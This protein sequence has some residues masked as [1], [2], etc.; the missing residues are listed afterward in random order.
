MTD[1]D[2]RFNFY[3]VDGATNGACCGLVIVACFLNES[4]ALLAVFFMYD[5]VFFVFLSLSSSSL[6]SLSF[7]I[8]ARLWT[9]MLNI[10]N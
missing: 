3:T 8:L 6:A 10:K 7:S 4:L 9:L 1:V 5:G 2:V